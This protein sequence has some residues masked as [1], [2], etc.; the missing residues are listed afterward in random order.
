MKKLL[1]NEKIELMYNSNVSVKII[2]NELRVDIGTIYSRLKELNLYMG[3]Y[4]KYS[5][6]RNFFETID[7]EKSAYWFGFL[8]AD[9]YNSG[10]FI[11]ID[12]Q[13]EFH[14]EKFRN[15]IYT[16]QDK[17]I[18]IKLSATGKNVYYLA[19]NDKKFISDCERFGLVKNK[20]LIAEYPNI[21]PNMDKHFIRGLFDGDG[22]L[23]YTM[24]KNYR[25]YT[26]SIV[27][28]YNMIL[29][30]KEKLLNIG[31]YVGFRKTKSIYELHIRGNR[32]IIKILD[33]LYDDSTIYLD[34]KYIK[35]N[36]MIIWDGHK[37]EKKLNKILNE[38]NNFLNI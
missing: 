1:D 29:S 34:R 16:N 15:E 26:F 28:S 32:Q 19:I 18:K 35:Y 33:W 14:L 10:N 22:C 20:S 9:G 36:D 37:R 31:I 3:R 12:I 7:T 13:D 6:N 27:G 23:T 11:R 8:M 25:R 21:D 2:A 24:D 30:V 17:P 4:H 5:L 38:K